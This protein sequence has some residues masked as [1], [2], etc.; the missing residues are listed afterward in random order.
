MFKIIIQ[1]IILIYLIAIF[2]H[3]SQLQKFNMNGFIIETYNQQVMYDNMNILNPV[4][5]KSDVNY[6][7]NETLSPT[8]KDKQVFQKV[9]I[10]NDFDLNQL[11]KPEF[12]FP[13][14]KSISVIDKSI[15]LKQCIHNY[16]IVCI[17]EGECIFYL[18]NPK[19]KNEI[20]NK[21]NHQIKKWG[22]K[23]KVQKSDILIIP[24]FWSY[25]QEVQKKVIQYHI[26]I[27][28]YFTV[29][30]NFLKES[31]LGYIDE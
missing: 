11:P 5:L 30:P 20:Q 4:L 13:I 14:Y 31:Y 3:S 15:P 7:S 16:N 12:H 6:H 26:D 2:Y 10:K 22:H 9:T 25:I 23:K 17:L 19:H 21:E 27:D 24:P 1:V 8:F 28:S 18:F 29:I